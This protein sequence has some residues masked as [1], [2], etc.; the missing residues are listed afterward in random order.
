MR[1][2]FFSG[3]SARCIIRNT[4]NTETLVP[5]PLDVVAFAAA[6]LSFAP[7]P[8]AYIHRTQSEPALQGGITVG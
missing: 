2:L 3:A 7:R 8:A 5:R 4:T 1:R 6:A